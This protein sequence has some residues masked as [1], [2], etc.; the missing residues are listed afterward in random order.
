MIVT[1]VVPPELPMELSLA[2]NHSLLALH[3]VGIYCTEPFRIPF[4]GRLHFCCF[5]KTGT[6][7]S[8]EMSVLG[9]AGVPG[10][11]AAADGATAIAAAAVE[12][13]LVSAAEVP[14][15]TSLVLAGCQQLVLVDGELLGDPME[16]A[17]LQAAGWLFASEGV[18][19]NRD[20]SR[21]A[22]LRIVQRYPFSSDLRRSATI[23]ALE[24]RGPRLG[25]APRTEGELASPPRLAVLAK[26]APE[27]MRAL[28]A[29]VPEGYDEAYMHHVRL[30]RRVLALGSKPLQGDEAGA[31]GL[32]RSE[33][34]HGL[35]FCGFLVLH[36]PPKPESAGVLEALR[37][38][39]H[40]LQMITGDQLLTACQVSVVSVSVVSVSV[41][42]VLLYWCT[43]VLVY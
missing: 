13:T 8:D 42:S 17:A 11:A 7:T 32:T 30:G 37:A 43:G 16:R 3:R 4:A 20:P 26:G 25:A 19:V 9:V 22:S 14:E 21:R 6:L 1:S 41:V 23:A 5:D 36:C 2:V 34:E 27:A 40:E 24:H 35:S 15:Q 12:S 33:A 31:R 18:C 29:T 28:L 10:T 39:S 38:S